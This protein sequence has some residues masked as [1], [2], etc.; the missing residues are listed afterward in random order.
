MTYIWDYYSNYPIAEITNATSATCAFTSFESDGTGNWTFTGV[1]ANDA[2]PFTGKRTYTLSGSNNITKSGLDGSKTYVV[3]Y[4][5][6]TG[7]ASVN[8]STTAAGISR[9]GWTYYEHAVAANTTSI[10]VSGS[11]TID[12][13]RLFPK[14][15]L[16]TTYAYDPLVG[17]TSGCDANNRITYYEYD[18]FQRLKLIKDQDRNIIKTME[19][20]YKQ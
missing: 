4:W 10:T 18:E 15:S 6:K 12:E 13:L 16:M 3:S 5:S 20:K 8:G 14:G 17:M 9:L 1:P 2:S 11:V 19:Y 7:S